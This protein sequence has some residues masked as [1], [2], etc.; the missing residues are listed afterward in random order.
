MG[1]FDNLFIV[2]FDAAQGRH[3]LLFIDKMGN[4]VDPFDFAPFDYAQGGQDR[5]GFV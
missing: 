5:I 3:F 2:P 4:L 1:S